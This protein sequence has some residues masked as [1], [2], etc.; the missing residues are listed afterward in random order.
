MI[1][2]GKKI[3]HRMRD[4]LA[5]HIRDLEETPT[6]AIVV[7]GHDPVIERFVGIKRL[8]AKHAGVE[9]REYRFSENDT[10]KQIQE[11]VR[12][13]AQDETVDGIVVQLPLPQ[14]IDRDAILSE[15]PVAK[16]VD[17]I[18]ANGIAMFE[19]G[20][21]HIMPPVVGAMKKIL[22]EHA[23]VVE[24]KHVVIVGKGAL[25]GS[26]ARAWFEQQGAEVSMYERDDFHESA[27]ENA[28]IVVLGAGVPGLIQPKMI[29]DGVVILDAG[30]SEER[31]KLAG[32]ADE[33]CAQKASV[34]TPVPGGI[35]PLTV[36]VLFENVVRAYR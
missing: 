26:P 12:S 36:A 7:V 24:K 2:D 32:D 11:Q 16:D 28:D 9:M 15:I 29:P 1:V 35:G 19:T 14:Q 27:L 17:V 4:E 30:T 31:G 6:L 13:L 10:T 21:S 3:T 25:V 23:V 34:F 22:E 5:R 20:E 18:S 33:A 8:Y